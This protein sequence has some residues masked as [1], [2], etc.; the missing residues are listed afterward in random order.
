MDPNVI[1]LFDTHG[2]NGVNISRYGWSAVFDWVPPV[3]CR[4]FSMPRFH[5][6]YG[7][8]IAGIRLV[9]LAEIETSYNDASVDTSS[10]F[11]DVNGKKVKNCLS[12]A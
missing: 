8:I 5:Q 1:Q 7:F 3:K 10:M 2:V 11:I 12:I 6:I 4:P 9:L